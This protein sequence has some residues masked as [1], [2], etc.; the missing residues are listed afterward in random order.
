M[1]L[2]EPAV[3]L[4]PAGGVPHGA[5]DQPA[6]ADAAVF[7]VRDQARP[8]E[9]PQVLVNAGEGHRERPRQ[10]GDRGLARG[11]PGEDRPAGRVRERGEGG[12]ERALVMLNHVVK[13]RP[14]A[15][16]VKPGHILRGA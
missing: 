6:T 16:P 5:R 11:K 9:H 8:R 2:P 10:L 12:V 14:V 4:D 15:H 1:R 3:P 7:G 13:Y